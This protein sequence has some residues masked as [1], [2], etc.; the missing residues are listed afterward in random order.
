M[1]I[2]P[3]IAT[4]DISSAAFK[5]NPFPYFAE[6][7]ETA[8]V[9][10]LAA[11]RG[12]RAWL[13]TRYDDVEMVLRS[14]EFAKDLKNAMTPEQLKKVPATPSIFKPLT[15][16][17]LFLDPPDHTRLR[18]LV[19]KA[20][21][22]RMVERMSTQTENLTHE[23]L[24]KAKSR[25]GRLDLV[26]DYG[27]PVPSIIIGRILGVP[28]QDSKQFQRWSQ[29]LVTLETGGS[30]LVKMV[31]VFQ[32]MRYLRKLIKQRVRDPQDDLISAM[33][34]AKEHDDRLTEDEIL[35]MVFLLLNAGNETT[36]NLI[37]SGTLALLDHPEQWKLL[38][39][40]RTL[41]KTGIE[42]LLRFV[43]PAD[44]A[45]ERYTRHDV[46]VAG[47]M[48]PQGELVLAVI[49][50]ANRDATYFDNPDTLDV[51]RQDNKH[52]AFGKGVHYC[53]GAPLARME[54]QIAIH[55]LIERAPKLRLTVP[56]SQLRWHSS[57][58]ARGLTALPVSF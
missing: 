45:T 7:R 18:A 34:L 47:T 28:E 11:Y 5:A 20:F 10:P 50:S 14:D 25:G 57:F 26:A 27:L 54:G 17:L 49:A 58:V 3:A 4:V 41:M 21:T 33:L 22:P 6:L 51:S 9:Y 30:L 12:R 37:A 40:D 13:V 36:V 1:S 52:L 53:V 43:S 32:F 16:N 8:P 15:R 35:A 24:D 42:E 55:A 31:E 29:S 19:H 39:E 38:Q 44:L 48:I 46:T 23:I 56:S 2:V